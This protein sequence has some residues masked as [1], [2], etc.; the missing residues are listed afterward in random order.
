MSEAL[1][2]PFPARRS[3][4]QWMMRMVCAGSAPGSP[5]IISALLEVL[6]LSR[7]SLS[8]EVLYLL[9]FSHPWV[10]SQIISQ[11]L[12]I[13]LSTNPFENILFALIPTLACQLGKR[14]P[15]Y[16]RG[17]MNLSPSVYRSALVLTE[18]SSFTLHLRAGA[19][20][21]CFAGLL[22][23]AQAGSVVTEPSPGTAGC[24]Q[25]RPLRVLAVEHL[26]VLQPHAL[27]WS[28]ASFRRF[29]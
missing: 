20:L 25:T 21:L 19:A 5:C 23:P 15:S 22:P 16:G 8:S 29:F 14:Q 26:E 12:K 17:I 28:S 10:M 27:D 3:T 18:V 11:P 2:I 9:H 4:A 24:A 7:S 1:H 6:L 13:N